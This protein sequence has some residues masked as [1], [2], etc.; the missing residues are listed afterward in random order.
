MA[1][2]DI[3]TNLGTAI[4]NLVNVRI[5]K[6]FTTHDSELEEILLDLKAKIDELAGDNNTP[7]I[8]DIPPV[9]TQQI[10]ITGDYTLLFKDGFAFKHPQGTYSDIVLQA[11][12]SLNLGY[13]CFD[14]FSTR[15]AEFRFNGTGYDENYTAIISGP[16][17]QPDITIHGPV[18]TVP[19]DGS[20]YM[21][22][23]AGNGNILI[24][25]D[26]TEN[27]CIE[28]KIENGKIIEVKDLTVL[29]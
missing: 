28:I 17:D 14:E 3:I 20:I 13:F 1:L 18:R 23:T 22:L 5:S 6:A 21:E 19:T 16:F 11:D 4:I 25:N 27:S 8:P 10:E 7:I 26:K 15:I 12:L 9:T 24:K 2:Q 29:G